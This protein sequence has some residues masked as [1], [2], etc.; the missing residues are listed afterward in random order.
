VWDWDKA[1]HVEYLTFA[2]DPELLRDQSNHRELPTLFCGSYGP[3]WETFHGQ[4]YAV[5]LTRPCNPLN[6]SG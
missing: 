6:S 4:I 2:F 5:N 1:I 3:I